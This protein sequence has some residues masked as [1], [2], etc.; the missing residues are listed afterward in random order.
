MRVRISQK[1]NL[2]YLESSPELTDHTVKRYT[3]EVARVPRGLLRGIAR[4]M[5]TLARNGQ[6]V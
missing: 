5:T 6:S 2:E 1:F 4:P 3:L